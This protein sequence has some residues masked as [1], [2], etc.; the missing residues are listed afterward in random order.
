M[1]IPQ[2][3]TTLAA[4]AVAATLLGAARPARANTLSGDIFTVSLLCYGNAACSSA[5]ASNPA[6]VALDTM[7]VPLNG[8]GFSFDQTT[9]YS[10]ELV[11]S[12]ENYPTQIGITF[13]ILNPDRSLSGFAAGGFIGFQIAATTQSLQPLT[14]TFANATGSNDGFTLSGVSYLSGGIDTL[15]FAGLTGDQFQ[16]NDQ[17]VL[18]ISDV[19]PLAAVPE[20]TPAILLLTGLFGLAGL[21]ALR[22]RRPAA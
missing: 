16:V 22:R 6:V 20:P 2:R 4:I 14:I 17:A 13:S 1:H 21:A 7:L 15:N 18:N 5:T 19:E 9:P 10:Q 11:G 12:F 3:F 8:A